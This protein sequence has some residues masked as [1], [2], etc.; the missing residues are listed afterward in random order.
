MPNMLGFYTETDNK[1]TVLVE[2]HAGD[3]IVIQLQNKPGQLMHALKA[4]QVCYSVCVIMW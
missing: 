2:R 4:F 3:T 1:P